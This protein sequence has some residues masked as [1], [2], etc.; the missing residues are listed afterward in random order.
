M[1]GPANRVVPYFRPDGTGRNRV[2]PYFFRRAPVR[3]YT[4]RPFFATPSITSA[5]R[6]IS[7][8]VV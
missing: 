7:A 5:N 6:S 2:V 1:S 8:G 4:G 3:P